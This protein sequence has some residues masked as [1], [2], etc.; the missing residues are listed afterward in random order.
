MVFY[1][2][3]LAERVVE[4][5]WR[6]FGEYPERILA[7]KIYRSHKNRTFCKEQGICI[8]SPRLGCPG[9]ISRRMF[10]KN[11]RKS[12]NWVESREGSGA[13]SGNSDCSGSWQR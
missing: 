7:D 4:E 13:A 9:K 8:S 3:N 6:R 5:Y 1:I 12:M 11:C 10:V 2:A